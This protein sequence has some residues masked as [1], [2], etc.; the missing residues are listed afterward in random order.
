MAKN[1]KEPLYSISPRGSANRSLLWCDEKWYET[2]HG[3]TFVFTKD[4]VERIKT[5]LPKHFIMKATITSQNGEVEEW[6]AFQENVAEIAADVATNEF[7][8][9]I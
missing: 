2:T 5:C 8:C 9:V 7:E 4:D 1:K 3:S 6:K